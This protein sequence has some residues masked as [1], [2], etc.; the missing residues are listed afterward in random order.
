VTILSVL[1]VED[2]KMFSID[3]FIIAVFCCV[4]DLL[5]TL[6]QAQPIRQRGVAPA[7]SDSEVITMEIVGE[8]QGIDTDQGV[9]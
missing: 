7:L 2:K 9:W 5:R 8:Y 4:D 3:E 6:T 1:T